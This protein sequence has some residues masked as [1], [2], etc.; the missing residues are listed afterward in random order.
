MYIYTY[1]YN[2]YGILFEF[3]VTLFILI[4]L[5]ICKLLTDKR[6]VLRFEILFAVLHVVFNFYKFLN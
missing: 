2:T 3:Y 5:H 1:I 4:A 6:F